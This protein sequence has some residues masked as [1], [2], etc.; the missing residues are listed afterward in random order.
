MWNK[1]HSSNFGTNVCVHTAAHHSEFLEEANAENS[2]E[3]P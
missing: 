2:L 1:Q 3:V